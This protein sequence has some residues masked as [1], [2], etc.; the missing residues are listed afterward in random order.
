MGALGLQSGPA[1][2]WFRAAGPSSTPLAA[3]PYAPGERDLAIDCAI[4]DVR[5][6]LRSKW[7]AI[8]AEFAELYP[9][10]P[11]GAGATGDCI[12]IEV[13]PFKRSRLGR[14]LYRVFADGREIGGWRPG[15]GVFP[16]VE[17]GINLSV[18]ARR[19]EFLQLHAA[20]LTNRG[21]GFIFA[22][23][24]GCGKSTLA[25][26]LLANGWD[27]LCDEF[28]L[29]DPHTLC[30]HPFRKALC[31]KAGSYPII[32]RLGL[33][34]A[35]RRDYVKEY[36]GRVNYIS[37]RGLGGQS[38]ASPAPV[39][40]ILFPQFSG[41]SEPVLYPI[42]KGRAQLD[43]FRCCFNR[44]AFPEAALPAIRKLVQ[45]AECFRLEVGQPQATADLLES[46]GCQD[47]TP[48]AS[49]TAMHGEPPTSVGADMMTRTRHSA[50]RTSRA[51]DPAEEAA[52]RRYARYMNRREMLRVGAKFAYLAPTVFTLSAR[53]AFA[54]VSN[55]SG[56]CSTAAHTGELCETDTDCCTGNC[57]LGLCE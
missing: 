37:P 36:K 38:G 46:L 21:S 44:H 43:L 1:M 4:G 7:P 41:R 25:A 28:A 5:V 47:P 34:V 45:S 50:A 42:P 10:E 35:R 15:N 51:A 6:R 40:F 24:S 39:R 27:Y 9:P 56:V 8:I 30:L 18:V 20:S 17:W 48:R 52:S 31:I 54:A 23:E 29:I 19:K 22:G 55:P 12:E 49:L 11:A 2:R 3:L 53:Q 26:I 16:L 13:Q 57:N 32:R 33:P 14:Q